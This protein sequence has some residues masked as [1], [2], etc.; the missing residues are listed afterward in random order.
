[1]TNDQR[2]WTLGFGHWSLVP[3]SALHYR[4]IVYLEF[5]PLPMDTAEIQKLT[6]EFL[7]SINMPGF[8]VLGFLNDPDNTQVVY[9][10][11]DMP[12]KGVVKGLTTTLNDL[13]GRM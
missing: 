7:R 8:V 12:L 6:E 2:N 4:R 11:K 1:M 5:S 3:V 13:M 9:S 10:I